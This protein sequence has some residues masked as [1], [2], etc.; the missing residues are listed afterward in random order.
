MSDTYVATTAKEAQGI[1]GSA[2]QV[3]TVIGRLIEPSGTAASAPL[4]DC[5]FRSSGVQFVSEVN[6]CEGKINRNVL[7]YMY[8]TASASG[9][10]NTVALYLCYTTGTAAP[11]GFFASTAI[12]CGGGGAASDKVLGWILP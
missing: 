8:P 4:R 6:S 9:G 1:Y 12:D 11:H 5:Y 2:L 7:G 10:V 3:Q